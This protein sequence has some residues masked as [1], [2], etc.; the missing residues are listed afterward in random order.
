MIDEA[1]GVFGRLDVLVNNAYWSR[2]VPITELTREV[3]EKTIAVCLSATAFGA[4]H[5]AP[6]LAQHGKGAIVSIASVHGIQ[7][8]AGWAP[9]ET[10]K[11]GL[12]SLVRELAVELGPKGIR[13]N[14]VS[15]GWIITEVTE[16]KISPDQR[17]YY[18]R[19][20]P[21]RHL[22][23]PD[24]IAYAVLYLAGD[25]S[26]FVTGHNLVVDGGMTVWLG[27][28]VITNL[29]H[30]LKR[31]PLDWDSALENK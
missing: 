21:V 25:E 18:S 9:Y 23:E 28:D 2:N 22:G 8:S 11:G 13:V 16:P 29:G 1:V 19:N 4:K 30:D 17:W 15:P 10:V 31:K 7:A 6:H 20:Y 26:R 24:D 5:A 27:E 12:I 3:W 14:A